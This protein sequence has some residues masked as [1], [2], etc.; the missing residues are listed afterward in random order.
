MSTP[1][2]G[3]STPERSADQPPQNQPPQE[4]PPQEQPPQDEPPQEQE[5]HFELLSISQI[6][7]AILDGRIHGANAGNLRRVIEHH[8]AFVEHHRSFERRA[9]RRE[10]D[11]TR[12]ILDVE[13]ENLRNQQY[14]QQLEQEIVGYRQE[15]NLSVEYTP[16]NPNPPEE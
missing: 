4:Q 7:Q 12:Q 13:R 5:S 16:T 11:Y 6:Y 3:A 2:R 14:I 1:P 8:L 9:L 15:L 10:V